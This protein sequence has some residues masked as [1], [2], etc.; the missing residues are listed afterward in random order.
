MNSWARSAV[1]RSG[2]LDRREF[3]ECGGE[4]DKGSDDARGRWRDAGEDRTSRKESRQA[5]EKSGGQSKG[6]H[7]ARCARGDRLGVTNT[8]VLRVAARPTT[9]PPLQ[10]RDVSAR[11]HT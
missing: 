1:H 2:Y 3:D 5:E 11:S 10:Y 8:P 7:E 4:E 9:T 6:K